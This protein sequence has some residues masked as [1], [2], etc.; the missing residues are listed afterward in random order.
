MAHA[1]AWVTSQHPGSLVLE[2]GARLSRFPDRHNPGEWIT[3]TVREDLFGVFDMIV[4]PTRGS[5]GL[6]HC[7]QV[8][9]ITSGLLN[10]V[11][12][13]QKKV[14]AW[15]HEE[16]KSRPYW[17]AE[18]SLVAWVSRK[19]LRVWA[20]DWSP[21]DAHRQGGW[22]EQPPHPAKLPKVSRNTSAPSASSSSQP[23]PFA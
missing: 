23:S 4:F 3:H 9:S 14:A 2:A 16:L 10:A 7:I 11:R 13:R 17:L 15:I 19:H 20:W 5:G 18:I 22:R 8:T 12:S 1:R 6:I 21:Q